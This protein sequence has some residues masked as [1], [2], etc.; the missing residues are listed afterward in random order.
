[1]A[2]P[3]PLRK[4]VSPRGR[5]LICDSESFSAVVYLCPAGKPTL[6]YGHVVRDTDNLKPPITQAEAEALL[7]RDLVPVE[8][9]LSA[10][11]PWLNQNQFDALASFC[12]NVGLG[13]FEKSTL[14]ARL[15]ARDIDGAAGQ[16]GRWILGGGK[17]LLGLVKRRRREL[18]LFLSPEE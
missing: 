2:P 18:E 11:F 15:K 17:I 6:G 9:Y 7:A 10:V 1:M 5:A 14:F 16:F 3:T 12:F 13:A 4:R 8:V